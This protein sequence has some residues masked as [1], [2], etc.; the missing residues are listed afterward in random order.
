MAVYTGYNDSMQIAVEHPTTEEE[1]IVYGRIK[2]FLG[3]KILICVQEMKENIFCIDIFGEE[4]NRYGFGPVNTQLY[5]S[6]VL[7]K[8]FSDV[9][10]ENMELGHFRIGDI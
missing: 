1:R 6:N 9:E 3:P 10:I 7:T 8:V 2:N 4:F 5:F